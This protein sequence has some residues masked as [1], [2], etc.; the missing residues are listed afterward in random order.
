MQCQ[1]KE[2]INKISL[3]AIVGRKHL[4]LIKQNSLTNPEKNV[5]EEIDPQITSKNGV[6]N[7]E[8]DIEILK[9]EMEKL[10]Q[11][12]EKSKPEIDKLSEQEVHS[13]KPEVVSENSIINVDEKDIVIEDLPVKSL[14]KE[15]ETLKSETDKTASKVPI[16]ATRRKKSSQK[17]TA[18]SSLFLIGAFNESNT[19]YS[20]IMKQ[21][22]ITYMGKVI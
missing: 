18:N 21:K 20:L 6:S 1:Q 16:P 22:Q 7:I 2:N 15:M 10:E 9:P 14:P 11:E 5:I 8:P 17:N 4:E 19:D 12:M 13:F 3:Q